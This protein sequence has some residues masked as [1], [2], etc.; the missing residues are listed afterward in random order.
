[1]NYLMK[2]KELR[3]EKNVTQTEIA[4]ALNIT[5]KAYSFYERGEREP[6]LKMLIDLSNFLM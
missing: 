4:N 3:K 6:N 2:L 5:Q 1:M